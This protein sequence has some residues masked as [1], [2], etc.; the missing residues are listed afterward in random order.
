MITP[1]AAQ[2]ALAQ[3]S[4]EGKMADFQK[5]VLVQALQD[6]KGVKTEAAR[7]LGIH[8]THLFKMMKALSLK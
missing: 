3:G 6:A 2:K 7:L 4:Y 1:H 5:I 8:R